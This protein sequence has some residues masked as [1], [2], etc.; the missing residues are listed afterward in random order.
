MIVGGGGPCG[1]P[2]FLQVST[3]G[4]LEAGQGIDQEGRRGIADVLHL[5]RRVC[6]TQDVHQN[7][8][9]DVYKVQQSDWV[10]Y[11][12]AAEFVRRPQ[13]AL[14]APGQIA[15]ERGSIILV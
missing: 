12:A 10:G 2:S 14:V 5:L 4:H 3:L 1:G 11:R 9:V 6:G 13:S 15:E 7:L 8:V